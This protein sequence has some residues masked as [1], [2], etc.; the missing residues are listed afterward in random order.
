MSTTYQDIRSGPGTGNRTV[1]LPASNQLNS[2]EPVLRFQTGVQTCTIGDAS[3]PPR[4]GRVTVSIPFSSKSESCSGQYIL[5][6]LSAIDQKYNRFDVVFL[7]ELSRENL[8]QCGRC[9]CKEPR[10]NRSVAS[11][12]AAAYSQN[13]WSLIRITFSSTAT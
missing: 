1:R 2:R 8:G 9:G 5:E 7:A 12:S 4:L 3:V 13:C 11:G 10:C 6:A